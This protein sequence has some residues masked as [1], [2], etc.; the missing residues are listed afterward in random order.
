MDP[1]KSHSVPSKTPLN[2][3]LFPSY[4][5]EIPLNPIK[6]NFVNPMNRVQT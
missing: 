1:T 4:I 2:P 3:I 5:R 6:S